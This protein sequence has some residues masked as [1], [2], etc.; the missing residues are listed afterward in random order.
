MIIYFERHD[1]KWGA[2]KITCSIPGNRT[3]YK[4]P[5]GICFQ[6]DNHKIVERSEKNPCWRCFGTRKVFAPNAN[7]H[8]DCPACKYRKKAQ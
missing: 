7:K 1:G 8:Y 2:G 3:A 4:N 5:Q 6:I